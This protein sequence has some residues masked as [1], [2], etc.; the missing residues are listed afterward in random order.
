MELTAQQFYDKYLEVFADNDEG[1][2]NELSLR[3]F[4]EDIK[5]SFFNFSGKLITL[6]KGG[7][8]DSA[9]DTGFE[10]EEG[11]VITGYFKTLNSRNG[12]AL[13][14]PASDPDNFISIYN[15]SEQSVVVG[16]GVTFGNYTRNTMFGSGLTN[17]QSF[18]VNI[19][20][21]NSVGFVGVMLGW[22]STLSNIYNVGV[23]NNLVLSGQE[24]QAFG[25][26]LRGTGWRSFLVG[27]FL[28]STV[29][30]GYVLGYGYSE[31][32]RLLNDVTQSMMFGVN[33][34]VPSLIILTSSGPGTVGNV[35]INLK[36]PQARL[37][38]LE[39][40]G[41]K[42]PFR[43]RK[44]TTDKT[45]PLVG[46]FQ[47]SSTGALQFCETAGTWKD[48]NFG[49]GVSDPNAFVNGGNAFGV[50][51][52]LGITDGFDFYITGKRVF[53]DCQADPAG[54]V[55]IYATTDVTLVGGGNSIA[56]NSLG[57]YIVGF[58][59]VE[60]NG[61]GN[62]IK[63]ENNEIKLQPG[64]EIVLDGRTR[65]KNHFIIDGGFVIDVE[66]TAGEDWLPIGSEAA[67]KISIGRYVAR[68]TAIE[69]YGVTTVYSFDGSAELNT[70]LLTTDRVAKFPNKDITFAGVDNETF[71]G[72]ITFD[73]DVYY[74][75]LTATTVP[76]LNGSKQMASSAITP[77][78]LGY[79]S[80][81]TSGI[82]A[83]I[84][85]LTFGL[86]WKQAV[87][88]AT[89]AN[90]T[91]SGTQTIDGIAVIVGDRVLVKNQS[92]PSQNGIWICAAG[93]WTRA[94]DL[95]AAAEFPS[96]TVAIS[97]GTTQQDT[98]YVCT[99]DLPITVG[100]TAITWVLVG[101]T[102]Y[103]GTTNRITVV[104]SNID[105][106]AT[107]E[108]LL[109]KLANPLSQF[110]S[111]TSAQ[112]AGVISDETGSGALVFANTPTFGGNPI[113]SAL[114]ASTVLYLDGT[115]SIRSSS[116][117]PTELGYLSGV[118]SA[119]QTQLTNLQTLIDLYKCITVKVT[120]THAQILTLNSAPVT[121][122]PAPGA[123]LFYDV[124]SVLGSMTFSGA[125]YA[126]NVNLR[127]KYSTTTSQ[128][129]ANSS[130][131]L[132][133]TTSARWG[134]M[135]VAAFASGS[136]QYVVNDSVI[137]DTATGDPTGGG[138]GAS[139]DV[140]VTYKL[141]TK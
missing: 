104:G 133:Q 72:V 110:A 3:N 15:D 14:T 128:V 91:L 20:G 135:A 95:D 74:D 32:Q 51:A 25:T 44:N 107:F 53:I 84:N 67:D 75:N 88:V 105:I 8:L 94:T 82:Q 62:V 45:V 52:T 79:L 123:G 126:T 41:T 5:D 106:S 81:V 97:E 137:L 130:V 103:N 48:F 2:I 35:G 65:L 63:L 115:K 37:D 18:G 59:L 30:S 127:V 99:N 61:N 31:S 77:T 29:T 58:P 120:L 9:F 92:T 71:T 138:V 11:G 47:F 7:A 56:V 38:I 96:A 42:A 119:I 111:T 17:T 33:S 86:S 69:L 78:E 129:I 85:A 136:P 70:S 43:I 28:Q 49:G 112:L 101:G 134:R 4:T 40:D 66:P 34:T 125:V 122:L 24:A 113:F 73:G 46:E 132:T 139:L 108:S 100:T 90:I 98:Q 93:A 131:I 10:I 109:G 1:L 50:D 87:R 6:N 124:I 57:T 26:Y 55:G 60:I 83:Q 117:T 19:G 102:T 121:I 68:N 39:G 23:G 36:D 22:S 118:T 116:V 13:K 141:M 16:D 114:T 140:Y 80:G 21:Q 76:Y 89:T 64:V 27:H 54:Q 12:F